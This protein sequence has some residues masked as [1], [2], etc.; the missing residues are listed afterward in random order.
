MSPAATAFGELLFRPVSQ[1]LISFIP[2]PGSSFLSGPWVNLPTYPVQTY[3]KGNI[4]STIRNEAGDS[5]NVEWYYIGHYGQLGPLTK[6]QMD[7]LIE[8]GVILKDTYIWRSGMAQWQTAETIAELRSA[9]T[10]AAPYVA[11]PPPPPP[12]GPEPPRAQ[13]PP[14]RQTGYSSPAP[15]PYAQAPQPVYP[16]NYYRYDVAYATPSDRS[17]VAAGIL[18]IFLPGVG[19]MYLGYYAYGVLQLV[20]ALCTGVMWLWPIIDGIMILTGSVKFDGFGRVL[21][22]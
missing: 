1:S 17:R 22:E 20:L 16:V 14:P 21:R 2:I 18:Q 10:A 3:R 6:E 9:L 11:P 12:T 15:N 5:Q 13:P 8:G 19:R 7:E 4:P